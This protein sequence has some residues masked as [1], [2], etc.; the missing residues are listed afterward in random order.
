MFSE[1]AQG[2]ILHFTTGEKCLV[3][4]SEVVRVL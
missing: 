4:G 2:D 3:S 1:K